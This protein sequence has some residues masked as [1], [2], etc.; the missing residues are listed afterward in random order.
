VFEFAA[1]G[2]SALPTKSKRELI[3]RILSDLGITGTGEE[4]DVEPFDDIVQRVQTTMAELNARDIVD[5]PTSRPSRMKF[6]SLLW[7]TW[8]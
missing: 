8:F 5:V 1:P 6:S 2:D 4:S 3:N 7:S